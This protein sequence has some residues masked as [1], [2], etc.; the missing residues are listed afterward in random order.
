MQR[1]LRCHVSETLWAALHDRARTTGESVSHIVQEAL[2]DALAVDHHSLFQVST[3]GAV[4]KGVYRGCLSVGD[5]RRHGDFG[6]GTFDGLDGEMIMLEG[7][8]Y[9]A[10]ADGTVTEASDDALT[11]FAVVTGFHEDRRFDLPS[12]EGWTDLCDA[13]DGRRVSENVFVGI[14]AEGL[15]EGITVRAACRS[16]QGVDLVTA[17]ATQAE[18]T[19]EDVAG[20]LVG[21]W[22]PSYAKSITVPGYHLHFISEDR[23]SGGHVLDIAASGLTLSMHHETDIHVAI[24][25]TAEFLAADLRGD[26]GPALDVA[27]H[28]RSAS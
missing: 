22:T 12:I 19:L 4:V 1:D 21:F 25:E 13:I 11:P 2:A 27:E 26:P 7:H 6:L 17:T 5:L 24:P 3:S 23:R 10:R 28:G 20:T 9:Q 16:A 18:F 15:V 14:R 8:C